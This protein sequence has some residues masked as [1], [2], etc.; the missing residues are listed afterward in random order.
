MKKFWVLDCEAYKNIFPKFLKKCNLSALLNFASLI[1]KTSI[2]Y[3][4]PH[5]EA[6]FKSGLRLH[7]P[8]S[9]EYFFD[10]LCTTRLQNN[11]YTR[12]IFQKFESSI[13]TWRNNFANFWGIWWKTYKVNYIFWDFECETTLE[14]SI[15]WI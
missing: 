15:L 14:I 2:F 6:K 13:V 11:S 12:N 9:F 1:S 10:W 5:R 8:I 3:F 4:V 7:F